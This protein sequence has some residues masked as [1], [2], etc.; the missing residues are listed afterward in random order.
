MVEAIRLD[1]TSTRSELMDAQ[2]MLERIY[3]TCS[4]RAHN[5][6]ESTGAGRCGP[7]ND[8]KALA[9]R[10]LLDASPPVGV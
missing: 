8:R 3:K 5:R 1:P 9:G 2:R 7:M 4:W 6:I 10:R